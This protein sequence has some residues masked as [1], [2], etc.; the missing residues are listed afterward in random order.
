MSEG[1]SVMNAVHRARAIALGEVSARDRALAEAVTAVAGTAEYSSLP[2]E[3]RRRVELGLFLSDLLAELEALP[4][5]RLSAAEPSHFVLIDGAWWPARE[6]RLHEQRG[7][8]VM[9]CVVTTSRRDGDGRTV[10][11]EE[12]WTCRWPEWAK[13]VDGAPAVQTP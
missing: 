5:G 10:I 4:L 12:P 8:T 1:M 7:L 11:A 6:V 2:E 9:N 13:A 3:T